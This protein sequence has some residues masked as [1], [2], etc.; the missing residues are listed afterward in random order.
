MYPF[1]VIWKRLYKPSSSRDFGTM[2]HLRN[3]INRR[4]VVK[5]PS[6]N[7]NSS[8][9][10]LMLMLKSHVLAAFMKY[11]SMDTLES[12]P[13]CEELHE[14]IFLPAD[15]RKQILYRFI[16]KHLNDLVDV[17]A[18]VGDNTQPTE[19][20]DHVYNYGS[21]VISL[22]LLYAEFNDAIHEGDGLRVVRC[23]RYFM[24]LFRALGHRNYAIEA[25][26][27][28][29]EYHWLLSPRMRE[30][31]VW[32]RFINVHGHPGQNIPCDFHM[33]HMNRVI[34]SCVHNLRANKSEKAMQRIG[35]CIDTLSLI[36]DRYNEEHGIPKE[37]GCHHA[38]SDE[39]DL[40]V[41]IEELQ[42]AKV[43]Y[44]NPHLKREHFHFKNFTTNC[45][46]SIDKGKLM[47]WLQSQIDRKII[48]QTH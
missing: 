23:Y 15:D 48:P 9:D 40:K 26:T 6:K 13:D 16:K 19:S 32:S 45:I 28:L 47:E 43:F 44:L 12:T 11:L 22:G 42:K 34:K 33:E 38:P 17:S 2:N 29:A 3:I 1:Q 20:K 30:Q 39:K 5:D 46:R 31:L 24:L 27:M 25:F 14:S 8:E 4:N 7:V 18:T 10:F 21:E 35:K 36:L 41:I 37:G